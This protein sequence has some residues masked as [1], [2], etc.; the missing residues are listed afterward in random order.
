MGIEAP[1]RAKNLVLCGFMGV[2]KTS[3]GRRFAATYGLGFVDTDELVAARTGLLPAEWIRSRG[4][5]VFR[6]LEAEAVREAAGRR[7]V[8]IATGGGVPL[9]EGNL[10]VLSATGVLVLLEARPGTLA[11]RLAAGGDRP[12]L[13]APDPEAITAQLAA[14][15]EAYSRIRERLSTDGRDPEDLVRELHRIWLR[16]G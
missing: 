3:L 10:A 9:R 8:V 2:G 7:G 14:R 16:T 4:E 5:E 1:A 15:A 6:E 13:A 12:L 11:R